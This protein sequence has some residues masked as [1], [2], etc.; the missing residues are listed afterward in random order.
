MVRAIDSELSGTAVDEDMSDPDRRMEALRQRVLLR[1]LVCAAEMEVSSL[2][3]D[4][5]ENVDKDLIEAR[6]AQRET[7]AASKTK[8]KSGSSH[9]DLT[10][11]LL[12]ALPRLLESF[13][14]EDAVMQILTSL[15]QYFC[16]LSLT[17][18]SRARSVD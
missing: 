1:F 10:L 2:S 6:E 15:P 4:A 14:S 17:R 13:K 12:G 3:G 8:Q 9:E 11:A 16:K 7:V 5:N 18:S